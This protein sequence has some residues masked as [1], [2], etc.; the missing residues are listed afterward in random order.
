MTDNIIATE[1]KTN[2]RQYNRHRKKNKRQTINII[3]SVICFS[4][5]GYY[6]VCYLFFFLWHLYCLSFVF[7]SVA[8]LLSVICLSICGFYIICYLLNM[9]DNIIATERKT[10]DRQYNSHRKKNISF[11]CLLFFFLWLLY[12]LSFVFLSVAIILPVICFSVCG[13]YVVCYLFVFLWLLYFCHLFFFLWLNQKKKNK[14]HTK[15]KH[16]KKNK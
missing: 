14:R 1:R 3:L 11:F 5:C 15:K 10:N 8:I 2:D 12:C 16:K 9:T 6:I 13:F 7:L 4:F